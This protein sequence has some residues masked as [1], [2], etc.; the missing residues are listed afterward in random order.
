MLETK[1]EVLKYLA[2]TKSFFLVYHNHKETMA[3]AGIVLFVALLTALFNIIDKIVP[4]PNS[5]GSFDCNIFATKFL[6]TLAIVFFAGI[7][8]WYIQTQFEARRFAAS[9]NAA[10]FRLTAEILGSTST[11]LDLSKFFIMEE[12]HEKKLQAYHYLPQRVLNEA[13]KMKERGIGTV[14]KLEIAS[15]SIVFVGAIAMA[16]LIWFRY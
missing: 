12:S 13:D 6:L 5:S 9:I 3:W 10:C 16:A 2:D 1:G 4:K 15:Y 14:T 8:G 7:V 11:E